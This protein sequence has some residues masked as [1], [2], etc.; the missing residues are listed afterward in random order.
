MKNQQLHD[1]ETEFAR[2]CDK[3][4]EHDDAILR[5]GNDEIYLDHVEMRR[6]WCRQLAENA[7]ERA[8]YWS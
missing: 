3:Q 6:N 4:A 5:A 2:G 1:E 8:D 7:R